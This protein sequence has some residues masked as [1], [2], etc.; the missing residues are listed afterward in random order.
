MDFLVDPLAF[1]VAFLVAVIVAVNVNYR[2]MARYEFE[3]D[4]PT[5][6]ERNRRLYTILSFI[7]AFIVT[8]AIVIAIKTVGV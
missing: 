6:F 3:D 8:A 1:A 7:I 2:V 4:R 5:S